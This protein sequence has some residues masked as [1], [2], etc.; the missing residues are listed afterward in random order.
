[1]HGLPRHVLEKGRISRRRSQER[2]RPHLSPVAPDPSLADAIASWKADLVECWRSRVQG[3]IDPAA[4]PPSEILDSLPSFIDEM[5]ALLRQ[6]GPREKAAAG[7]KASEI[8][9]AH[10]SQRFHAGFS[11]GAVIREYGVLRD[12]VLDLIR[13]R[14]APY[15]LDDLRA[16]AAIFSSAVANAAEQFT[17]ERDEAIEREGERHFGFIAHELRNP[18]ASA[19]LAAN[20]LQRRPGADRDTVVH[21]LVRNLSTLRHRIDNSLVSLRIRHLGRARTVQPAEVSLRD[22]VDAVKE[23]LGGDAQEKQLT[24]TVE[25]QAVTQADP[26]LIRSAVANLVG[27]AVK[28]TRLGGTIHIRINETPELTSIEIE[29]ECGGLPEGKVEELFAPFAQRGANRSGF[30]LGLA[31]TKD[32]IEAHHGTVQISNLPGKGCVFMISL[33]RTKKGQAAAP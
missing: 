6:G 25:G 7:E 18:L 17:R 14:A 13:D 10:G 15:T 12:C 29:D 30:G 1:M 22:V 8:A 32:A 20:M 31:I 11:L 16:V 23:D 21:R 5:I 33:P 9:L 4:A 24:I 27:N 19:L 2:P 28:Y 3:G 26:Q